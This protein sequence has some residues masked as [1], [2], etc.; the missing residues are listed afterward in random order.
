MLILLDLYASF[1]TIDHSILIKHLEDI[2]IVGIPLSWVK[3]YL[4]EK[5]F[6]YKLIT[7]IHLLVKCITESLKVRAITIFYV[8]LTSYLKNNI[9]N[10]PF[11]KYQIFADDIQLYIELLVIA[12]SSDNIALIDCINMVKNWFLQN[13]LML[14]MNKNQIINISRTS[15]LFPSVI[16]DSITIVPCNNVKNLGFIFDDNLHFSNQIANVCN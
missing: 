12:N 3:L 5:H 8:Y 15:L 11:V 16:I 7:I 4:S 9:F 14:N 6:L 13:N 2:G 10:F 1:D